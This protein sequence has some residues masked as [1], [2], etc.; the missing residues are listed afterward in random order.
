V[1]NSYVVAPELRWQGMMQNPLATFWSDELRKGW[2]GVRVSDNQLTLE[3]AIE[4][5]RG[6]C[7]T[8]GLRD[9]YWYTVAEL[10][11]MCRDKGLPAN[12]DKHTLI[13]RLFGL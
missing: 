8:K 12:G 7:A 1:R 4:Q 2:S 13:L 5:V 11:Q 9:P 10:Q 6:K 3:E